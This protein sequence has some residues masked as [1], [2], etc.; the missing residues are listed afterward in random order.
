MPAPTPPPDAT[1]QASA[2]PSTTASSVATADASA[3][4]SG[5]PESP[6]RELPGGLLVKDLVVGTGPVVTRGAHV[7]VRYIGKL[8]GG[9]VFD[10]EHKQA[11]ELPLGKHQLIEGW[12]RGLLGMR[13]GGKRR[14]VI[15]PALGYGAKGAPPRIP[16]NA[17]IVFEI[18]LDGVK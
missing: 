3:A 9:T 17:V 5:A 2:E 11:I 10:D 7:S 15:P 18:E 12:E 16:P 8:V 4:A 14:L 1:A 13:V 6:G